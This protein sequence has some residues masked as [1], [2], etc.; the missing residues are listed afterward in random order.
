MRRSRDAPHLG[1]LWFEEGLLE[2]FQLSI[3]FELCREN[4]RAWTPKYIC[5]GSL[6]SMLVRVETLGDTPDLSPGMCG[7]LCRMALPPPLTCRTQGHS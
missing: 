3:G 2:Q 1:G 5:K 4:H 6:E 7:C